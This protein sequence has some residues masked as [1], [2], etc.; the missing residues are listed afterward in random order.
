MLNYKISLF[1]HSDFSGH[2]KFEARLVKHLSSILDKNISIEVYIGRNGEFDIFAAS[3]LK[4]IQRR[5]GKNKMFINLVISY[6]VRDLEYYESY[7][8]DVILPE[9]V[10]N[11]H[12]KGAITKRNKWMI[13]MSDSVIC[14]VE[15]QCGGAYNVANKLSTTTI[16]EMAQLAADQT[17]TEVVFDLPDELE[18]IGS[19]KPQN[20]VLDE[21]ALISLGWN[22]VYTMAEGFARTVSILKD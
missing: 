21:S 22:G 4:R 16:C 20:A 1:G 6:A 10:L 13:D 12:P 18:R 5:F 9:S 7:Y 15:R 14:Y 8:D 19:S 3:V 2:H 17:N 11:S